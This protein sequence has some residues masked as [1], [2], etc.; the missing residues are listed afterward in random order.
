MKKLCFVLLV[1][2]LAA[3]VIQ[4]QKPEVVTTK[5]PGWHKI[6]DAT[7]DF[8]S[9]RDEFVIVGANKFRAIRVKVKDAPIHIEDLKVRFEGDAME[10]VPLRSQLR[11]GS[12]SRVINLRNTNAELRKVEF[13]YHTI[14]NSKAE[15]AQVE[16][17]GL[18]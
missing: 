6:G 8:K 17:W 5:K 9:D 4:A 12:E 7:V 2:F 13:V 10:D 16:L 1:T 18:K 3:S 11:A 15:R 14:P